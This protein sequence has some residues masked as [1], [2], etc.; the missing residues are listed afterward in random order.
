[1]S[2]LYLMVTI[3]NRNM[4]AKFLTFYKERN[5]AISLITLGNGTANSEMLDYFGLEDSEKAV[6]FGIVTDSV[7]LTLKKGLQSK[8]QIDIPGTGI[9]FTIPLSS[10]GG[11]RELLFLTENQD[12][13]KGAESTL[14]GCTHDLLLVIANQGYSDSVSYTHLSWGRGMCPMCTIISRTAS[15]V[16]LRQRSPRRDAAYL[17]TV[18]LCT[19]MELLSSRKPGKWGQHFG[20]WRSSRPIWKTTVWW[21]TSLLCRATWRTPCMWSITSLSLIHI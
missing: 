18:N 10:I 11:K 5:T 20:M 7:W 12:Y 9:A 17:C 1:M 16:W 14:T 15:T 19:G 8:L 3:T 13:E 6:I 21:L 4:L 2:E